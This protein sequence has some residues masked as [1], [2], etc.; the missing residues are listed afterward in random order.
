MSLFKEICVELI[1]DPYYYGLLGNFLLIIDK[2]TGFFNATQFCKEG[3][4]S[5]DD[6][7]RNKDSIELIKYYQNKSESNGIIKIS[8]KENSEYDRILSG[9]YVREEF[10]LSIASWISKDFYHKVYTTIKNYY[11]DDFNEKYKNNEKK[12]IKKI[13]KIKS[14]RQKV[15]L[16]NKCLKEKTLS[17]AVFRGKLNILFI[18]Q[19]N[20]EGEEYPY[21]VARCLK[22][23][24]KK[25]VHT[26]RLRY[27]NLTIVHE[28]KYN[29]K[30]MDL[31]NSIKENI[32]YIDTQFNHLKVNDLKL[33]DSFPE[34]FINDIQKLMLDSTHHIE[35]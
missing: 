4:K 24:Y 22:N 18:I 17:K 34:I 20:K 11:S 27:P 7:L 33:Q 28:M 29:A 30:T 2:D 6:W 14:K 9:T 5:I 3:G 21:Y 31:F 16:E 10:I 13:N 15:T 23:I 25:T 12:R 1:L 35:E 26:L 8:R 19:K 32:F